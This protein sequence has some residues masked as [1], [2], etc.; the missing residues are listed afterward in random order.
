MTLDV[1]IKCA[2]SDLGKFV[3]MVLVATLTWG[4]TPPE[5][6]AFPPESLSVS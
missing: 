5:I 2:A 6:S 3:Y 1:E 4:A